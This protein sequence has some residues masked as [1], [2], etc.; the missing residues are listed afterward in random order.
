M[1]NVHEH[2]HHY[3]I[4]YKMPW[5]DRLYGAVRGGNVPFPRAERNPTKTGKSQKRYA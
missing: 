4:L 5:E 2:A 1:G 3:S